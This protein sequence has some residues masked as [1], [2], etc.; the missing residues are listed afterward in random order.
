MDIDADS[1]SGCAPVA[2]CGVSC[3][4]TQRREQVVSTIGFQEEHS[5]CR[6]TD[7]RRVAM[8]RRPPSRVGRAVHEDDGRRHVAGLHVADELLD[9][10]VDRPARIGRVEP[11]TPAPVLDE[12]IVSLVKNRDARTTLLAFGLLAGSRSIAPITNFA[13]SM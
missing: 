7:G 4:G 13:A 12:C 10:E 6:K 8:K 11:Q 1:V 9:E 3:V 2:A 5:S